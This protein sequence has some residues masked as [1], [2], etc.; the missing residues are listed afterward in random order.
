MNRSLPRSPLRVACAQMESVVGDIEANL[1]HH[2]TFIAEAHELGVDLLLFPEL[3]LMGYGVGSATPDLALRRCDPVIGRLADA[4]GSMTV[5]FGMIEEGAAAQFYNSAIAVK[6]GEISFL[7]RKINLPS[8]GALEEGKH[9]AGGR[10]VETFD[11]AGPWLSS[12]LICADMWNPALVHLAALHGCTLLLSPI[13]SAAEAVGAEFDNPGG[14][15]L[16]SRY[17][18]MTYGMPVLICNRVGREGDL[19]FYGRSKVLDPFGKPL[20]EA[21]DREAL[22]VADLDYG[23]LR[24]ARYL[25]PTVRDSNLELLVREIDRLVDDLGVPDLVRKP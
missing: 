12:V 23:V 6:N 15:D 25:L 18:A 5:V 16:N 17:Y 21:D 10:Y 8:Y 11:V 4:A 19:H 1:K 14:W 7:H 9:Y 22:M 13:S 2:L 24:R 3:S 20:A